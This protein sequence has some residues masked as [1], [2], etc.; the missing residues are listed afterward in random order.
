MSKPVEWY[1]C[2]YWAP[3]A[4]RSNLSLIPGEGCWECVPCGVSLEDAERAFAAISQDKKTVK[5]IRIV[6]HVQEVILETNNDLG[7]TSTPE[8]HPE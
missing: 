5:K 6:R 2:E 7:A 3:D 4:W 8:L 1:T